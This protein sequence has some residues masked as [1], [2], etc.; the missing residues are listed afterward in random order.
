M[1][2]FGKR[3]AKPSLSDRFL[4]A[5]KARCQRNA[6][7]SRLPRAAPTKH[8]VR[9]HRGKDAG[10]SP[11]ATL[12]LGARPCPD[13]R[14]RWPTPS[15]PQ[16]PVTFFINASQQPGFPDPSGASRA[17][18]DPAGLG[19]PGPRALAAA[20]PRRRYGA[21]ASDTV[22][23]QRSS[24]GHVPSVAGVRLIGLPLPVPQPLSL[25]QTR[26]AALSR[27]SGYGGRWRP[28]RRCAGRGPGDGPG[29]GNT[30]GNEHAESFQRAHPS[31]GSPIGQKRARLLAR[32]DSGR[33]R[34]EGLR[35]G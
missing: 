8:R 34:E 16:T 7:R 11:A 32:T 2:R 6:S 19:S 4:V 14:S 18:A 33:G 12:Q 26:P 28:Q 23:K 35:R 25:P 27:N 1:S 10:R 3:K 5:H 9:N 24:P 15:Q 21:P 13:S 31:R 29:R 30:H 17:P 20:R 22:A